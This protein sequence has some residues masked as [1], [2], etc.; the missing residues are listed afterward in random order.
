M[1]V[2]TKLLIDC[3]RY[4]VSEKRFWKSERCFIL[5]LNVKIMEASKLPQN[6]G[7]KRTTIGVNLA[8]LMQF[9][10]EGSIIILPEYLNYMNCFI[11]EFFY[12]LNICIPLILLFPEY[13]YSLNIFIPWLFLFPE[14]FYS[15]NIFIPWI[16]LFPL[17]KRYK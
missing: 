3:S 11:L 16:F 2:K 10:F 9:N 1:L 5:W 17:S 12:S 14:Y 8:I 13:F 4:L 15:L 7:Q 6:I